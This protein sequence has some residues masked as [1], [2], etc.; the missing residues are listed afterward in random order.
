MSGG[1]MEF[2]NKRFLLLASAVFFG[3]VQVQASDENE[4]LQEPV[5]PFLAAGKKR[6]QHYYPGFDSKRQLNDDDTPLFVPPFDFIRATLVGSRHHETG[7]S[8]PEVEPSAAGIK[9]KNDGGD[10]GFVPKRKP[11]DDVNTRSV[12]SAFDAQ[13]SDRDEDDGFVTKR[14]L[15]DNDTQLVVPSFD[16]QSSDS[17]NLDAGK[18]RKNESNDEDKDGGF[19]P[20]RQPSNVD[21]QSVSHSVK[22]K[23]FN[24]IFGTVD[25]S[26]VPGGKNILEVD[27]KGD[28]LG[29]SNAIKF[30]N[31]NHKKSA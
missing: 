18:K 23:D 15:S 11:S 21:K 4:E 19:V 7:M 6:R 30:S 20:K 2:K 8:V 14:Q 9:R 26:N 5:V 28:I 13:S 17:G 1:I 16:V 3:V 31:F 27:L 29:N 22:Q 24:F 25:R 12:V 10:D